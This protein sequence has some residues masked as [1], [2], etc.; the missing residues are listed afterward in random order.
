MPTAF[1]KTQN[2]SQDGFNNT[3]ANYTS[4]GVNYGLKTD[5]VGLLRLQHVPV[6]KN[7]INVS[8]TLWVPWSV[9][10][11]NQNYSF[12]LKPYVDMNANQLMLSNT[13]NEWTGAQRTWTYPSGAT[14]DSFY[15]VPEGGANYYPF[16]YAPVNVTAH[17]NYAKAN[18]AKWTAAGGSLILLYELSSISSSDNIYIH[19]KEQGFNAVLQVSWTDPASDGKQSVVNIQENGIFTGQ[20]P[21]S[22]VPAGLEGNAPHGFNAWFS[23]FAQPTYTLNASGAPAAPMGGNTIKVTSSSTA[24]NRSMI[25]FGV[26]A[27]EDGEWYNYSCYVYVPAGSPNIQFVGLGDRVEKLSSFATMTEKDQ[28]KRQEFSFIGN[29]TSGEWGAVQQ[30]DGPYAAGQV[31]YVANVQ[32]TK[33]RQLRPYIDGNQTLANADY[34]WAGQTGS[35]GF[36]RAAAPTV[37]MNTRVDAAR[38]KFYGLSW[39][40]TNSAG[41]AQFQAETQIRRTQ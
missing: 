39:N 29:G 10:N 14:A 16:Q 23:S 31:F 9:K 1:I 27:V 28:W 17:I 8:A 40:Y 41:H 24:P 18:L 38:R 26:P 32:L 25:H 30:I 36:V 12:V 19:K 37:T 13:R 20:F 7:A 21:M 2:G 34:G 3:S 35:N 15:W 6:P 5:R 11:K 33:G 22:D 4:T